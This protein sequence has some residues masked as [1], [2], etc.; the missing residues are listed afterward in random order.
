M[1]AT[2]ILHKHRE[3]YVGKVKTFYF[4]YKPFSEKGLTVLSKEA[5]FVFPC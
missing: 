5:F 3:T 4:V 2:T 1:E